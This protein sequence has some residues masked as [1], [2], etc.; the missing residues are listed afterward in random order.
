MPLTNITGEGVL[1]IDTVSLNP[2]HG[3]WG[4][5]SDARGEGG[6]VK[7]WVDFDVRGQ[8]RLLPGVTGVIPYP[9]RITAKR[10]DLRL[11]VVGDVD[12]T[13]TPTGNGVEGLA[14]NLAYLRD[15]LLDPVASATGTRDAVLT[16][17]GQPDLEGPVHVLGLV[18][19][20]Y[21]IQP[22]AA[23]FIGTLQLSLPYGRLVPTS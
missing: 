10:I 3:A 23:I 21:L 16:V 6:L 1:E 7:L 18:T 19:Q 14:A 13:G 11:L 9:R 4:V 20:S 22:C 8:D 15:N 12:E 5:V 17:P 2:S